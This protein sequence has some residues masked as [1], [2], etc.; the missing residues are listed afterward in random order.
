M[1]IA[2][3]IFGKQ[4]EAA[5]S[6]SQCGEDLIIHFLFGVLKIEKPSYLDIGAFDPFFINNTA[7]LYSLGSRGWNI[8]PNPDLSKKFRE[9][10]PRDKNV[11]AGITTESGTATFYI[12]EKQTLSTFSEKHA[13]ELVKLHNISIKKKVEVPTFSLADFVH[14][15]CDDRFPDLL[16]I[17]IE[18]MELDVIRGLKECKEL[19][20]VIC[21][22]SAVF[23]PNGFGDKNTELI[24]VINEL[25]FKTYADTFINTIFL[26]ND[27]W[28]HE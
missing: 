16:S 17:D 1:N 28:K 8:E 18:G 23:L 20:K 11:E 15:Q 19:P 3:K 5:R 7:L 21:A 26:R 6:W 24:A 9:S 25:G 10:R 22:E 12:M 4:Q 27:L 2:G 13:E 14:T